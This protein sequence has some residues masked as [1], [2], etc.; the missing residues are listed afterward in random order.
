LP[1]DLV[2]ANLIERIVKTGVLHRV[3]R[4]RIAS[5]QL[6]TE[7][8]LATSQNSQP[9]RVSFART[10]LDPHDAARHSLRCARRPK[11]V[12]AGAHLRP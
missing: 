6:T 9:A 1:I 8:R 5:A 10:R 7:V 12:T 2:I 4:S 11:D 3:L